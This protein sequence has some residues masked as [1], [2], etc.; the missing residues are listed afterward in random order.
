MAPPKKIAAFKK[1]SDGAVATVEI[2]RIEEDEDRPGVGHVNLRL[3][4]KPEKKKGKEFI[5]WQDRPPTISLDLP[6]GMLKQ[7]KVGSKVRVS[8]TLAD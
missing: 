8:I 5:D 1:T 2:T 3:G 4:P 6:A 7:F